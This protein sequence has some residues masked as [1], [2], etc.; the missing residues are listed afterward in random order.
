MKLIKQKI[1]YS[2]NFKAISLGALS[3]IKIGS[4]IQIN[5]N[6]LPSYFKNEIMYQ[7]ECYEQKTLLVHVCVCNKVLYTNIFYIERA[8]CAICRYVV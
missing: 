7:K 3:L 1:F 2:F 6:T 4:K 8:K 5:A